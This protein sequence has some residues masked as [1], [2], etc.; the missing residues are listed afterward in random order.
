MEAVRRY[1]AHLDHKKRITLRGAA[2]EYYE[3]TEYDNGCILL[4]PRVVSVPEGIS[5]ETLADIDRSMQ[6]YSKGIVSEPADITRYKDHI[7]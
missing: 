6:N 1:L 7:H 4:V 5:P 3:C 2:Y